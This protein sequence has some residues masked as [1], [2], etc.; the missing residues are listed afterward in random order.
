ML[1]G[2]LEQTSIVQTESWGGINTTARSTDSALLSW[3][4]GVSMYKGKGERVKESKEGKTVVVQHKYSVLLI[5]NSFSS[6]VEI[7][8][9]PN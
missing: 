7:L 9:T 8:H 2:H 1:R 6:I 4:L 5:S 3:S